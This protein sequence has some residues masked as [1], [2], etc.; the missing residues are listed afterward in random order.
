MDW[1]TLVTTYG[2][3]GLG[4]VFFALERQETKELRGQV[5]TMA[6]TGAAAL[7]ASTTAIS[8]M[9]TLITNWMQTH[10]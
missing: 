10:S 7:V 1:S 9:R 6:Q 5:L 8:E 4:W 3:L 2:P